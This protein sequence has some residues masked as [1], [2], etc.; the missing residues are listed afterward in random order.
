MFYYK[1]LVKEWNKISSWHKSITNLC[2]LYFCPIYLKLIVQR[3]KFTGLV[4]KMA[5]KE[6]N[7]EGKSFWSKENCSVE[8]LSG[9]YQPSLP[10]LNFTLIVLSRYFARSKI[11]SFFFFSLSLSPP[12][13]KR[14]VHKR[15][16]R[17][18]R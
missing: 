3:E 7:L 12:C 6:N 15:W 16:K 4:F 5:V 11:V 13:Y 10:P 2:P 1:S 18:S 14:K 17:M 8:T 9:E